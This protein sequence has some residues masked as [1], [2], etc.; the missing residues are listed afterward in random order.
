MQRVLPLSIVFFAG[1][2]FSSLMSFTEVLLGTVLLEM[3]TGY[4][5]SVEKVG[6]LFSVPI[7]SL[8]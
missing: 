7:L 6:A 3:I 5:Y 2:V 1:G 8:G 4:N